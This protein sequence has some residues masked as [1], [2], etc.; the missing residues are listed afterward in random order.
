MQKNSLSERAAALLQVRPGEGRFAA[1]TALMMLIPGAGIA[2]G[3]SGAESLLL[4]RV[5]AEALPHLYVVL[6]L[7]TIVTTLTITALLG[8][9]PALRFY[10]ILPVA[11][12]V[13][14]VAAR[15]LVPL[16]YNWI[17]QALWVAASLFHTLLQ[18]MLWG[19]AGM[20]WDTRQAKR[21]FPLFAAADIAGFSAGGL[22][23]PLLVSGL[24]TAN[25]LLG[26]A[27]TLL[28][29][30]GLA[31]I[32]A[33]AA[34]ESETRIRSRARRARRSVAE[35]LQAGF[36]YVLRSRLMFWIAVTA[37][38][39]QGLV[40][41]LWFLFSTA[42]E[43]RFPLEDDLTGFLG[44]FRGASTGVALVSSLLLAT[45]INARFGLAAS[46]L[47]LALFDVIGFSVLL[48]AGSFFAIVGLRFVHEVW[49]SGVARNAWQAL[50]NV[51][52]LGRREQT[53]LFINGV[54]L[55]LGA[56]LIG[57]LLLF[58][59]D[60]GMTVWSYLVGVAAAV[61]ALFAAWR[62][63]QAYVSALLES[64][65]AGRPL[66]FQ[67]EADPFAAVQR[68][69]AE[70]AVALAGLSD[71][72]AA[73]RR[74]ASDI[75]VDLA[76]A[77]MVAALVGKLDD[78]DPGVRAN[79]LRALARSGASAAQDDMI[80]RLQDPDPDVQVQAIVALGS[81]ASK[82][83]I[84]AHHLGPLLGDAPPAIRAASAATLL[85][86]GAQAQALATLQQ[87]ARADE[88]EARI[89]AVKAFAAWA[90]RSAVEPVS[91]ALQDPQPGVRR[92]A[93]NALAQ[94]G[95]ARC[96]GVLIP[97][98][99]DSDGLVRETVAQAIGVFDSAA[100]EATLAA[101]DDPALEAGAILALARLSVAPHAQLI[102]DRA[103][104]RIEQALYYQERWRR[105]R[106]WAPEQAT[107]QLLAD[108]L[109]QVA[110]R[111]G[112]NALRLLGTLVDRAAFAAAISS[113]GS[114]DQGQWANALEILDSVTE[115][116]TVRPLLR[117]WEPGGDGVPVDGTGALL[118]SLRD[119]E[120]WVRACA[121]LAARAVN[122]DEV[123]AVLTGLARDDPDDNV[124]V[125]AANALIGDPPMEKLKT[126]SMMERVL[127]LKRVPL[128]SD[129]APAEL[130]QVASITEEHL[131]HDEEILAEQDEPGDELYI[132]VSGEVQVLFNKAE[133]TTE[134]AR[135][136]SGEYVGEMAIIS[137]A[138]RSARLVAVGEVRTLCIGRK[139]FEV[140]LRER[141]ETSMAVMRVLCERLRERTG[142]T[143]G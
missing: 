36:R 14:L 73:V 120:A 110:E 18:I 96:L 76:E 9:I 143:V 77:D 22:I 66:V 101:L 125:T 130:K 23:T 21:L 50:F 108:S 67:N 42:V 94:I 124:R 80:V 114:R 34:P 92:A 123:N 10:L 33:S 60:A 102:R 71:P 62:I 129:L 97:A 83:A 29:A 45:R 138:P 70:K 7:I 112:L 56:M 75:L 104:V 74:V 65:R 78:P 116:H 3:V 107:A 24:G 20:A 127:F 85:Q 47:I 98:L 100:L 121:A 122:T 61:L 25:L 28:V 43:I 37:I 55:Q 57:A 90:D 63:R 51:V 53:R 2:I 32:L 105:I 132:I 59:A 58:A 48:V 84:L 8:R 103:R 109:Q 64:L 95:D 141:P 5:G 81:V 19:V 111:H 140:V 44:A 106:A 139:Q 133:R 113:L 91:A 52:P 136:K 12:A 128:F 27:A 72:D 69:A 87:M 46:F 38:L 88:A 99:G 119:S 79:L 35:D 4:S 117:L 1:L 118:E 126:L 15:F 131:F 49:Q 16:G 17:Y 11:V 115:R 30:Y 13:L 26:W 86:R 142:A 89:E 31:R 6:G 54:C 93:A 68:D 137:Q 134:L 82:P 40:Y 41:L 39:F 135:R